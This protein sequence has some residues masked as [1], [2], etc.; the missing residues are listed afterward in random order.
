MV[1]A[2]E[3][4]A[5]EHGP[6]IDDGTATRDQ[7]GEWAPRVQGV[8]P[9][10]DWPWKP[11]RVLRYLFGFPG[12]ILPFTALHAGVAVA[13]LHDRTKESRQR[14]RRM[15]TEAKGLV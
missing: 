9:L 1:Q 14:M 8:G 4:L 10:L 11:L 12:F 15:P 3:S 5:T 13:T 2:V 6:A 7:R